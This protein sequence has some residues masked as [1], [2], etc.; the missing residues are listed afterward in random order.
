M[1]TE[2]EKT[3]EI[4][5]SHAD[6]SRDRALI[7]ALDKQLSNL[8]RYE[9]VTIWDK[10]V[11]LGG[12]DRVQAI[13]T[14]L[15]T[16]HIILLFVSPDFMNSDDCQS[17]EVTHAMQR[18][19]TGAARVIPIILRPVRW[20][21]SSFGKLECLPKGEP[22]T[23]WT[24]R[25]EAFLQ[26][27]Q[28]ISKVVEE[29]SLR[30]AITTALGAHVSDEQKYATKQIIEVLRELSLRQ[31]K[32]SELK[33]VHNMLH[34]LEV[35]LEPLTSLLQTN[36]DVPLSHQIIRIFWQQIPPKVDS[37]RDFAKAEMHFLEEK[38]KPFADSG[39]HMTGP[40]W[41]TELVSSQN[42]FDTSLNDKASQETLDEL[43]RKFLSECRQQLFKIDR[44]LLKEVDQL[45]GLSDQ[46][47]RSISY[48]ETRA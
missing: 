40:E 9:K 22:V 28:E 38:D 18:H 3:I 13:V 35:V 36:E 25:E 47:L 44:R 42:H 41:A 20:K 39:D 2:S 16:A 10:H 23:N 43:A 8:K 24:K 30:S 27:A 26:I 4:F 45:D 29:V 46:I 21:E 48:G 31:R 19:E 6:T 15:N 37:I 14:H 33:R 5:Y 17:I 1:N 12:T 11:L 32:V 7:N 34:E